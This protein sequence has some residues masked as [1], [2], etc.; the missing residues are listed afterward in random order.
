MT[1]VNPNPRPVAAPGESAYSDWARQFV[2]GLVEAERRCLELAAT[3]NELLINAIQQGFEALRSAPTV[4]LGEWA[5]QGLENFLETQRSWS[6][7]FDQQRTQFFNNQFQPGSEM[8]PGL[9]MPTGQIAGLM[10]QPVEL[11]ADAR[12]RWL[13]FAANQNAQVVEGVKKALGIREG[14]PASTYIDWSQDAVTSYVEF[15]KRWLELLT[16]FSF[17]APGPANRRMPGN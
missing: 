4:G 10:T 9:N 5:R 8:G 6:G 16:R 17:Q 13:E 1:E 12:V 2:E 11:L 14:T 3:Q 15:Q 7:S